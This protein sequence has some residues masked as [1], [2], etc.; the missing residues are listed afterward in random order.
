MAALRIVLLLALHSSLAVPAAAQLSTAGN[1]R[2]QQGAA[3]ILDDY[4]GNDRFAHALAGGDFNGDGFDDLAVGV[5][6]EDG[7][8]GLLHVLPGSPRGLTGAGNQV[9]AQGADG[10]DDQAERGDDFTFAM[11]AA[12]FGA[13][14]AADLAVGAP[15]EDGDR[16]IA[17]ILFGAGLPRPHIAAIVGAGAGAV[18]NASYNAILTVWGTDFIAAEAATANSPCVEMDGNRALIFAAF[19]GQ[20]NVQAAVRPDQAQAAVRVLANCDRADE[21]VGDSF[22]LPLAAGSPQFF[23][24]V[25]AAAGRGPIAAVNETTGALVG[26]AGLLPGGQFAP[27]APRDVG[28]AVHDRPGRHRAATAAGPTRLRRGA[29]DAAGFRDRRRRP[30]RAF[31]RGRHPRFRRTLPGQLAHPPRPGRGPSRC[32]RDDRRR[33]H[34][35]RRIFGRG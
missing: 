32:S 18:T 26:A 1:Q 20:I 7:N 23:F 28:D 15:G 27:A 11:A 3:G 31:L 30:R 35:R 4:E 8:R 14:A 29:S 9:F 6:G 25:P 19:P 24:F 16:G 22:T 12:D 13:D 33:L 10:L 21:I 2:W 34:P 5:R 17:H